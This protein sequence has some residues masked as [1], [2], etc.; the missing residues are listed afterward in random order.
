[1]KVLELIDTRVLDKH[2]STHLFFAQEQWRPNSWFH[3]MVS[4]RA[5][6]HSDYAAHLSPKLSALIRPETWLNIRISVGNGFKSPDFRQLYLNF[7][8]PVVGYSVFGTSTV[9]ESLSDL[10]KTGQIKKVLIEPSSEKIKPEVSNSYNIGLE[11]QPWSFS[12]Y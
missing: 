12:Q 8:N 6:N 5:D 2:L 11:M 4:A 9:E 7:T 1:M 3:F 10:L